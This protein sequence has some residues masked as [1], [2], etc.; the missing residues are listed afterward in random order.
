MSYEPMVIKGTFK[1]LVDDPG[2]KYYKLENASL[3]Q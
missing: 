1:V 3:I 2:G